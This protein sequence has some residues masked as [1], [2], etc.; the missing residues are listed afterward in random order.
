MR[1]EGDTDFLKSEDELKEVLKQIDED[2]NFVRNCNKGEQFMDENY[3]KRLR[4]IADKYKLGKN[5][6]EE[7]IFSDDEFYNLTNA[8]G[9]IT[10]KDC[11]VINKHVVTTIKMLESLPYPKS[12]RNVPRFAE[13]HHER[14]DGNGYPNRLK[15]NQ[16]PLQGRIIAIADIFE[17][18]TS[19]ERPYKKE[20][21]LMESLKILGAMKE[22]G[23][24]DP[25][26]FDVFISEEVYLQYAEK[27]LNPDQI[28][29]V[30]LSKIPGSQ[31]KE[32]ES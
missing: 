9:T 7:S 11:E 4:E 32:V 13:A 5:G 30:V 24:I 3:K 10:P 23:H 12:L 28:D 20:L 16:I 2:R 18:L 6:E 27:Y 21:T 25:D 14:M 31:I 17:A 1:K 29:E 22:N 26:L 15:G 19:K 8:L